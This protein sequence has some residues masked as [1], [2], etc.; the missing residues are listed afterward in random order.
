M[1]RSIR[2]TETFTSIQGE[3]FLTGVPAYFVRF[4]GCSVSDCR[5][6]PNQAGTCDTDWGFRFSKNTEEIAIDAKSSGLHWCCITGG[7]PT[8]Q[9]PGLVQLVT[10]L[11]RLNLRVALQTSGIREATDLIDWLVVSPKRKVAE[12]SQRHGHELKLVYRGQDCCELREWF[13]STRFH[14]YYLQPHWLPDGKCNEREAA[15]AV[16]RAS[17]DNTGP[18]RLSLQQH[19]YWGG[20]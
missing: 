3:G 13:E 2:L 11:H 9:M 4:A 18:W 5:L 19:K 6:H 7:E 15:E 17:S 12:I 8:D 14:H 16:L 1:V 20:R 10:E